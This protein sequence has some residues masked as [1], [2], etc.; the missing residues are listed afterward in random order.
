MFLNQIRTY[1]LIALVFLI[2][3]VQNLFA[4]TSAEVISQ[5]AIIYSDEELTLPIGIAKYGKVITIG[6][7]NRQLNYV[8]VI[9]SGRMAY[10]KIADLKIESDGQTGRQKLNPSKHNIDS[11]LEGLREKITQNNWFAPTFQKTQ[12]GSNFKN[13]ENQIGQ[14]D[15]PM[16]NE[17][18]ATFLHRSDN[19][20]HEWGF[21]LAYVKISG[22]Q[23]SLT[24]PEISVQ[25]GK[26]YS[27]SRKFYLIP[28][29]SAQ[30]GIGSNFEIANNYQIE[31]SLY[32]LGGALGS[33]VF[34]QLGNDFGF[35]F[36]GNYTYMHIFGGDGLVDQSER[37]LENLTKL[38]GLA[39]FAGIA[40]KF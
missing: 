40:I 27:L 36:G 6:N 25:Y 14:S 30:L 11:I 19:F 9:V 28:F 31:P 24:Y 33:K 5:E 15:H 1:F 39:Y 35:F 13:I 34:Y 17:F 2:C 10:I 7:P 26:V 16:T 32:L 8:P 29:A 38:T 12:T 20:K 23:L 4:I 18:K 21:S 22:E 3:H 37:P